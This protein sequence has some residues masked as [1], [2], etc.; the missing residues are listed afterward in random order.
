M[1][2]TTRRGVREI[3]KDFKEEDEEDEVMTKTTRSG[4]IR[5]RGD[6]KKL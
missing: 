3:A 2:R 6:A 4:V 5:D 1:T